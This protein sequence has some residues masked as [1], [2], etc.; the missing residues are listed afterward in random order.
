MKKIS[1]SFNEYGAI[2]VNYSKEVSVSNLLSASKELI[3]MANELTFFNEAYAALEKV[4]DDEELEN[5]ELMR[6]IVMLAKNVRKV[7]KDIEG[8]E[9]ISK[10]ITILYK[11]DFFDD[12]SIAIDFIK[13]LDTNSFLFMTDSSDSN[14]IN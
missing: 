13:E 8:P 6:S 5:D 10:L 2:S 14:E 11:K 9:F 12:A 3:D 1:I 7:R 4:F